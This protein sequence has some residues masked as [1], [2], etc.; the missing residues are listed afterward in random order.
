MYLQ[1]LYGLTLQVF[2]YI[3][4]IQMKMRMQDN[5]HPYVTAK[6]CD[7]LPWQID[8][9]WPGVYRFFR[10]LVFQRSRRRRP[11]LQTSRVI[12]RARKEKQRAPRGDF[13]LLDFFQRQSTERLLFGQHE[14]GQCQTHS[15]VLR[16][17]NGGTANAKLIWGAQ[18]WIYI[19]IQGFSRFYT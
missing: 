9:G 8:L 18:I 12:R 3:A 11:R 4:D 2:V 19:L 14:M 15:S 13:R 1:V 10:R 7:S 17:E 5:G 16:A 6:V